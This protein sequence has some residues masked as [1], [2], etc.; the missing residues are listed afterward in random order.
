MLESMF[1]LKFDSLILANR[2]FD[3]FKLDFLGSASRSGEALR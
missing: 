2:M 1:E 3:W